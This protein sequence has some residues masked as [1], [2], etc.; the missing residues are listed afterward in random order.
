M[1]VSPAVLDGFRVSIDASTRSTRASLRR[2]R[3]AARD[4]AHAPARHGTRL[5]LSAWVTAGAKA[6]IHSIPRALRPAA[7]RADARWR[8]TSMRGESCVTENSATLSVARDRDGTMTRTVA[9]CRRA[10]ANR[11]EASGGARPARSSYRSA[12][13]R[14][15]C[16]ASY[17]SR[18]SRATSGATMV[19]DAF[20]AAFRIPNLLQNLF[21]E[22]ALSASFIP[23]YAQLL[24][25]ERRRRS[26]SRCRCG[27]RDARARRRGARAAR[28]VVHAA[29][30]SVYW[31]RASRARS[32][33]SRSRTCAFSFPVPGCS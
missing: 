28:R 30:H 24:V 16:S 19:A 13:S 25:A 23:V 31:R 3:E 32:A 6:G 8:A 4:G 5:A 33:R 18:S 17:G 11:T 10:D 20:N 22:G 29:A 21:G 9:G 26:W 7:R 15:S 1:L 27:R 2:R 14:R 12:S